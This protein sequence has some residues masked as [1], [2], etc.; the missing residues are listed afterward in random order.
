M[1]VS[2]NAG[3]GVP[4]WLAM[5][6]CLMVGAA[7]GALNGLILVKFS[8]LAPMIVT[9][10]TQIIFRGIALMI[11]KDQAAGKF[12]SWYPNLGWGYIGPFPMMMAAFFVLF[13]VFAFL[14]HKTNYGRTVYAVGK[15]KLACRFSGIDVDRIIFTN[16]TLNGLMAAVTALFLTS[17]MGSTRPNVANAYEMDVIAMVVLGGVS[18]A[19]GKGRMSGVLIA[20]FIV[21]LLRYGLGLININTQVLMMVVGGLLVLAVAIPEMRLG[22]RISSRIGRRNLSQ[23]T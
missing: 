16:F 9:L 3:A 19:G 8:E 4:M 1:A 12:P 18:T 10:A 13:A 2:F 21:G 14:L 5:V 6:I 23:L 7:C 20:I 11:L 22:W 15:N 17:R